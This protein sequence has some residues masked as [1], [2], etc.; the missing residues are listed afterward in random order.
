MSPKLAT[1]IDWM[2][3]R[4]CPVC[5]KHFSVLYPHLWR[6]KRGTG[7][8]WMYF[9]KYSCLMEYDR[10]KEERNVK[11]VTLKEKKKAAELA[12]SGESPLKYLQSLG[13]Q[14]PTST[15][16]TIRE[17]YKKND[18][19]TYAKLPVSGDVRKWE[20]ATEPDP[21]QEAE[22]VELEQVKKAVETWAKYSHEPMEYE[23][24]AI[25]VKGLGEFYFDKKFNSIDWR[26]LDGAETSLTPSGW[27]QLHDAIPEMLATL[28]A[29]GE[30]V[31]EE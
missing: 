2:E 14:N 27:M 12:L 18:P 5:E 21:E 24:T 7:N 26:A 3:T 23:T 15:W 22:N 10:R 25:R 31:A 30:K 1:G 19:E 13:V 6:Y 16:K 17:Y 28:H 4:V 20:D 29:N 11:Y 8:N 9:C